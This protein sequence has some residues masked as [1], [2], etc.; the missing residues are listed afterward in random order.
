MNIRD[1]GIRGYLKW[2]QRDQP[3]LYQ[4]IAPQ[5]VAHAPEA[6]SDHEQSRA[7]GS[8]MGFADSGGTTTTFDFTDSFGNPSTVQYPAS[9]DVASAANSGAAS[10]GI[11]NIIGNL[12]SVAAQGYVTTQMAKT[13]V[14]NLKTLNNI[15]LQRAQMG[16]EPLDTSSYNLGVPQVG[17]TVD[18]SKQVKTGIGIALAALVGVGLLATLSGRRRTA[19]A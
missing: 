1:T 2:L 9:T 8:L 19:R 15:Q 3:A 7:M 12:L 14:D 16:L 17:V 18:A 5:I 6:F 4:Q 13:Q 10:S 11:T